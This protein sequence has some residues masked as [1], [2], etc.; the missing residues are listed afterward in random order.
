MASGGELQMLL[1]HNDMD[2]TD[3]T[4]PLFLSEA[5]GIP[6]TSPSWP[7]PG[8]PDKL[9]IDDTDR[10]ESERWDLE[11]RAILNPLDNL[12]AVTGVAV[13]HDRVQGQELF[14]RPDSLS[15]TSHRVYTNLEWTQSDRLV[16]NGGSGAG[17]K[18]QCRQLLSP[19]V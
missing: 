3:E 10:F 5:L 15:E 4:T 12:R 7:L 6:D 2:V 16:L 13:R 9:V 8:L 18:G 11:L 1:Y 19:I 17:K 14:D